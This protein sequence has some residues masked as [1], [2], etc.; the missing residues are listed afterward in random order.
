MFKIS[1]VGCWQPCDW[2]V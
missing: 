2:I 1:F